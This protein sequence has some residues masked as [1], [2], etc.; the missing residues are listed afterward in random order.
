MNGIGDGALRGREGG[1]KSPRMTFQPEERRRRGGAGKIGWGKT[2]LRGRAND[3][4]TARPPG[5]ITNGILQSLR[6]YLL[7]PP[8]CS[9]VC[10]GARFKKNDRVS[11]DD[12]AAMAIENH[13]RNAANQTV[14][15]VKLDSRTSPRWE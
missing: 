11:R 14:S 5:A 9:R 4:S 12:R 7:F 8:L 3:V 15:T 2:N 1:G 13:S 10:T 6:L